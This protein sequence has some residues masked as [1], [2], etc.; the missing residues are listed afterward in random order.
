MATHLLNKGMSLPSLQ[1]ILD[2]EEI[3]TTQIYAQISTKNIEKGYRKHV[4]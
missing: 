2:H 1:A 4:G 3:T